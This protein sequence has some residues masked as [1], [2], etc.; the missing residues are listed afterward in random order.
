MMHGH[1]YIKNRYIDLAGN[2]KA[3]VNI[4]DVSSNGILKWS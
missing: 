2:L 3:K 1:T 4:E